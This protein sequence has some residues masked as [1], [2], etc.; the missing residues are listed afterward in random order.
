MEFFDM[1]TI[2]FTTYGTNGEDFYKYCKGRLNAL[3]I[4][5]H[6]RTKRKL[7]DPATFLTMFCFISSGS[8]PQEIEGNT[9]RRKKSDVAE[10]ILE[11]SNQV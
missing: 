2:C 11:F 3:N 4:H 10:D 7:V 1:P 5:L 8:S 9:H 6:L